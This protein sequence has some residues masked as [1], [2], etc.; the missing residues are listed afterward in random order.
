MSSDDGESDKKF[1]LDKL[2][3]LI[4]PFL[5]LLAWRIGGE[6]QHFVG[7][8]LPP[9][10]LMAQFSTPFNNFSTPQKCKNE[11]N[12]QPPPSFHISIS[13][14]LPFPVENRPPRNILSPPQI[15]SNP[16]RIN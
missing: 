5:L 11:A 10:N 3:G 4:V 15:P 8:A 16:F 6:L 2:A 12:F 1:P 9:A 14:I 7:R 13:R